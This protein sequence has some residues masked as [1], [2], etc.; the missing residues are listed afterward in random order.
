MEAGSNLCAMASALVAIRKAVRDQLDLFEPGSRIGIAVSG[1]A[2]SLALAGATALESKAGA[3]QLSVV[4]IDH[5]LQSGSDEA[6]R[7]AAKQVEKLGISDVEIRKVKVDFTDGLEASARRARYQAFRE[8]SVE[9]NLDGIFLGHT[10]N[11]QAENVLLGLA[12]GSGTRSLSGMARVN[13]IFHRPLLDIT[14]E[15]SESA[16]TELAVKIWE[17]PHNQNRE[18]TRVRARQLIPVLEEE[19]G[20]GISN[21]LARSAK[22]LRDDADA[23]DL[24]ADKYLADLGSS[25][26]LITE[27]EVEG[28]ALL[29]RAVRSRVLRRAIYRLGA[30]QGSLTAEHLAPIEALVTQYRGQGGTSLPGGVK[31]E[32]ISGR[33]SL[34]RG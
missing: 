24:Y 11:D 16:C 5:Q 25:E 4:I 6:A 19:L 30:P 20:P 15:E 14:R 10:K 9:K 12:R 17:D 28:L 26:N 2:D 23:L 34:S 8:W 22:L 31:V 27:L 29:P 32:R 1:G 21:A 7:N 33:L 18:F 13:E 3:H